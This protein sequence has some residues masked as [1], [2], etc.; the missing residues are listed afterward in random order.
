MDDVY[1][2]TVLRLMATYRWS[3]ARKGK[4]YQLSLTVA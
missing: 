1:D 2:D 4:C 3:L